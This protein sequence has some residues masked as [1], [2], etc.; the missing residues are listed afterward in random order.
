MERIIQAISEP[1]PG[2]KWQSLFRYHWPAYR[3]WFLSEGAAARTLYLSSRRAL[4]DHMPELIA[5]YDQLLELTG[6]GD[7]AARFLTL[8]CPPAYLRGCSQAVWLGVHPLLVRNYDYSP[9]LFEG[10]ILQTRW[11]GRL[12]VGTCDCLW[13]LVDGMNEDG[14]TLS[15]SFGGRRAVG[16]GF[17]VP[18]LLR[19]AL[20]FC[21]T[22]REA[23]EVLSRIPTHMSYNVTVL[24]RSGDYRTVFI[25]PDR[26]PL[27]RE[28]AMTTNHQQDGVEWHQH[29]RATA[30]LEREQALQRYLVKYAD[31]AH[32]LIR[33]FLRPPLYSTAYRR[34][35][36][37]LYT[38]VYCPQQLSIEYLWP[39]NSWPMSLFD[40]VEGIRAIEFPFVPDSLEIMH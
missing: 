23:V 7:L 24:D 30:T 4:R 40:V 19:Y 15:L 33:A 22:T 11:N 32:R 3:R 1:L 9:Q 31:D 35:F 6:G 8:Y 36:G 37:T 14:L 34:G 18:L 26:A 13:G 28:L 12:V 17:G 10:T 38:V 5:T 39:Q 27:I 20:E 2:C 21:S 25:A 16:E 29:A